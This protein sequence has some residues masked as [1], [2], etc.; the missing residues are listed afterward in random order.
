MRRHFTRHP[1][2]G[3]TLAEICIALL[4]LVLVGG[5]AYS[6][7]M[8]STT[9][10]A[11]NVALNQSNTILRSALDRIYSEINQSNGLPKL[12]NA[13]GS[14]AASSS[15]PAAGIIFDRYLG[16]PY[17]VTNPSGTGLS[18][19][20]Q[21]LQ[22]KCST[23]ALASP[24]VP[25]TNDVIC[26]D[27][28]VTRPLVNN[29]SVSFSGGLQTLSVTLK[30]PLGKSIPWTSSVQETA[31]LVH[32]KAFVI[33]PIGGRAEL[34]MYLDAETVT[35]YGDPASYLVLTREIGTQPG[36]GTPF[37]IV[38]QNGTNFLSIAMRVEHQQF[39]KYLASR[40]AQEFNTFL[41]IDTML[42][43]RNFL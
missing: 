35:N 39:N 37:T 2:S 11:K 42:R 31:Y 20:D 41:R 1:A 28:G 9:L 27:N 18:A 36:E 25:A 22:L 23:N 14:D 16:G 40:Q 10:L 34:R 6:M 15:G 21:S 19:T 17:V 30:A 33:A 4:L 12:I 43:P 26:M 13:D 7:L 8:N 24:P 32:R 29:C 3:Y 38:T 5:L